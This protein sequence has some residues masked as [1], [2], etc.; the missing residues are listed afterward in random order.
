MQNRPLKPKNNV[1]SSTLVH[2]RH[3]PNLH[4]RDVIL[5]IEKKFDT[6]KMYTTYVDIM[7][8]FGKTKK[9]AQRILKLGL[10]KKLLIAPEN[11]KP[12]QYYPYSK[13][14][15]VT[16][17][18]SKKNVPVGTT[19][20]AHAQFTSPLSYAL[21]QSK[22]NNFLQ[23]LLFCRYL[24]R[25]IHK[26]QL[27]VII[28]IKKL[29]DIDYYDRISSKVWSQNK[30]KALEE[31]VDERKIT[32]AYS[33]NG[34][35]RIW[36]ACSEKPFSIETDDDIFILYSFFGQIRDRLECH[37]QDPRGRLVPSLPDWI[38][39]QCDLNKDVPI[40]NQAQV[41]LPNI[42]LSTAFHV[43]RLY[44]KNLNGQSHYRIEDSMQVNEPLRFLKRI[45][46]PYEALQ[47]KID[48]FMT[49]IDSLTSQNL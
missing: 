24:S 34:T 48:C 25:Q 49:K 39:K 8:N 44:V 42:Q 43:F 3:S 31:F 41:S 16:E 9:Q 28:D 14:F 45:L 20:S 37:I 1:P 33:K 12:Q 36:V 13:R 38:L 17:Y 40:T 7:A 18:L 5:F 11:K 30:A 19:D 2:T 10:A 22:A 15:D 6:T 46:N 35:V 23:A 21:E 4:L 26:L 27:Q 47:D 29:L 32:F